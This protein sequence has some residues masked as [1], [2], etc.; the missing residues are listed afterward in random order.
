[1]IKM[2]ERANDAFVYHLFIELVNDRA[3]NR[4]IG[5]KTWTPIRKNET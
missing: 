2:D 4:T 1:M 3:T 5:K